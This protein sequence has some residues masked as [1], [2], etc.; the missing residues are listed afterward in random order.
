MNSNEDKNEIRTEKMNLK[1]SEIDKENYKI[2]EHNSKAK[3]FKQKRINTKIY[4]SNIQ[5]EEEIIH[6]RNKLTLKDDD[7]KTNDFM[8]DKE[9]DNSKNPNRIPNNENIKIEKK[10][11][12]KGFLGRTMDWL[13]YYFHEIPLLWKKDDLVQGYD[14]N[15]NIVYRPKKK[16]PIKEKNDVNIEKINIENEVNSTSIDYTTKGI[17]YGVYFN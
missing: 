7:I 14:A 16:I 15:G 12:K 13:N 6:V 8:C 1:I 17:Y 2:E 4:Q 3:S 10:K 5:S 11:E 9:M